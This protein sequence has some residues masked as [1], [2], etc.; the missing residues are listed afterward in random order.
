MKKSI[1]NLGK[2]LSKEEQ[3]KV[4]GEFGC[5]IAPPGCP[6]IVPVNHPCLGNNGGG[7]DSLLGTCFTSFGTYQI[8]CNRNCNDGTKPICR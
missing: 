5:D 8:P 6:C 4:N 7:G 3:Q 2:P 1:L